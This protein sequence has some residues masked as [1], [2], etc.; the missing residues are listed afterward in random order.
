MYFYLSYPKK[1]KIKQI[2]LV[3]MLEYFPLNK[4]CELDCNFKY[5][6]AINYTTE[7]KPCSFHTF[8]NTGLQT[9][10]ANSSLFKNNLFKVTFPVLNGT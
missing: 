6:N 1:Q 2:R 7:Y 8:P 10:L 4:L 5:E 9:N 3:S